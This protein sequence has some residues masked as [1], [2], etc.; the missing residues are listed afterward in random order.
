MDKLIDIL[1]HAPHVGVREFK[2]Q[3]FQLVRSKKPVIVTRQGKPKFFLI[4]YR[5]AF[6]MMDEMDTEIKKA[7]AKAH[8]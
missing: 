4:P 2:E 1:R 5:Q 8:G 7:E 3:L 6:E